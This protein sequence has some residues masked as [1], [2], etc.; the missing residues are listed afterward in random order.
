MLMS[1]NIFI[2]IHNKIILINI[3]NYYKNKNKQKKWF[4]KTK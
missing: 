3:Q 2:L 4:Y 1:L